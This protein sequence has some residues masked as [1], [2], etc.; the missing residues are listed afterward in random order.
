LMAM[1]LGRES[2][3]GSCEGLRVA[4]AYVCSLEDILMCM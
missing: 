4:A 2:V 3:N 1:K